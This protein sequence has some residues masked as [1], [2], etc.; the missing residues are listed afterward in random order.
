MTNQQNNF[1]AELAALGN[2]VQRE[3]TDATPATEKKLHAVAY[4]LLQ[5]E[6]DL[7]VPGAGITVMA[8]QTR[9]LEMIQDEDF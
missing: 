2:E 9:I 7:A 3:K 8:R 6:R 5:L 4:K 1:L